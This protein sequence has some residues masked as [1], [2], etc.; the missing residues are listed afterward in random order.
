MF[1]DLK[2]AWVTES[3]MSYEAILIPSMKKQLGISG[4]Y[5]DLDS[6]PIRPIPFKE[7]FI[8][9]LIVLNRD[10]LKDG[11]PVFINQQVVRACPLWNIIKCPM[12]KIK[13]TKEGMFNKPTKTVRTIGSR[14]PTRAINRTLLSQTGINKPGGTHKG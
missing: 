11:L 12:K 3:Y 4:L 1:D 14:P 7:L 8:R 9:W 2:E 6:L 13:L 10:R 5:L